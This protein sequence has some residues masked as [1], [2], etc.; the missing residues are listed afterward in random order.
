MW[1]QT[2]A[3]ACLLSVSALASCGGGEDRWE[4]TAEPRASTARI[5][6]RPF[7]R[8]RRSGG[9]VK[10]GRIRTPVAPVENRTPCC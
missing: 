5:A 1:L 2:S 3:A 9:V 4:A 6:L 10:A 7:H 8:I